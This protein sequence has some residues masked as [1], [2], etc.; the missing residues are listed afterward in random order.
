MIRLA[1]LLTGASCTGFGCP[2][3]SIHRVTTGNENAWS[4]ARTAALLKDR[5]QRAARKMRRN[6]KIICFWLGKQG[7]KAFA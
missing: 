3:G 1:P 6:A 4:A 7:E 5:A 2:F